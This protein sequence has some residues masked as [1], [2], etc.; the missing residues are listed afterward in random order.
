VQLTP[1]LMLPYK[2]ENQF[3]S[4]VEHVSN[5]Q[6]EVTRKDVRST[7]RRVYVLIAFWIY[8]D[9]H[10]CFLMQWPVTEHQRLI[11]A[12]IVHF[13]FER[14]DLFPVFI[15]TSLVVIYFLKKLYLS[16]GE[17]SK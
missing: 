1:N 17:F 3:T 16:P 7:Q 13:V 2:T 4:Y 15:A 14:Q 6:D 8:F 10:A 5:L 11:H 9:L 12:D